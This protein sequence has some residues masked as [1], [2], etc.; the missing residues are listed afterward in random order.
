MKVINHNSTNK[1]LFKNTG[2]IAIGQIST[3]I[4][5]FLL[6]PLYT[7]LLTT[8]E[9]GLVDLLTTYS[10]F[11]TVVIGLQMSQAV[12]RFLVTCRE[13]DEQVKRVTAT[14]CSA[15]LAI[16]IVYAM[17]FT[18]LSSVISVEYKWY[19]LVLVIATIFLQTTSG[20][21]RGL[22][23]N[24]IYATGNFISAAIMI[25]LN[26]VL[27]AVMRLGVGAMLISHIIGPFVGGMYIFIRTKILKYMD[28]R[29]ASKK[30][31]K[32]ILDYAIPLV[33]NE[34]SWTV[35]HTSD[36]MI[37][38][39]F[40]SVAA[41]GLI[42]V[43]AKISTVYT[44]AFSIFNTS[45]TEQ[46][47]LHYKDEGGP[48]YICDMFDKMIT[49]FASIAIGIIACIPLVFPFLVNK[50]F[51]EAY[52]LIP[53]YMIAVFFNAVIGMVAAI[54]L[55]ENETK[56][57]ALSTMVAALIN[58]IVDLALIKYIG[59]YAA[60]ISSICGYAVISFWRLWDINRRHCRIVMSLKKIV[61]LLVMLCIALFAYYSG[62]LLINVLGVILVAFIAFT[63]NYA[64]LKSFVQMFIKK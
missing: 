36:R 19:L 53:W 10:S 13:D 54:Y 21:A 20:I 5:N 52:G 48:E 34:L 23:M 32:T 60:P 31:L 40:L 14:V 51:E 56:Q 9:Y 63:L 59:M 58:V 3:K 44:T 57:V 61:V 4:V 15:T 30:E 42:A 28:F 1:A 11:I 35:I 26:V 6:L 43:A 39:T 18:L 45:W 29:F 49:F 27:I 55:I 50:S 17:G 47:V 62:V 38:S 33:P 24:S 46:V 22:G 2:I 41:N 64:F 25:V 16:M 12:F 8:E 7:A 37:I